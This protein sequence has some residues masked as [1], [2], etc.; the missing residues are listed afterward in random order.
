MKNIY[1]VLQGPCLTEKATLLQEEHQKVAFRVNPK[2]N[3]IEVKEAVEQMFDVK[4]KDVKTVSMR[5]KKKRVGRTIGH[6][7]DW[8]KAYVT[9]SEGTISFTDEL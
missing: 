6:T 1:S 2:A 8:K 4:V 5:G 3:K 9:L 7:G